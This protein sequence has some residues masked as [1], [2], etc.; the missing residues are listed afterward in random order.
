MKEIMKPHVWVITC[1]VSVSRLMV[2]LGSGMSLKD[3]IGYLR[4]QGRKYYAT[5]KD[6]WLRLE[7]LYRKRLWHQL[8]VVLLKFVQSPA[9]SVGDRILKLY[10]CFVSDFEYKINPMFLVEILIMAAPQMRNWQRATRLFERTIEKV[11]HNDEAF[12]LC[13][14]AMAGAR[15]S[16]V[17]LVGAKSILDGAEA[18]LERM[19]AVT[20]VHAR[21]YTTVCNYYQAL[22]QPALYYKY[23]LRFMACVDVEKL[24]ADLRQQWA[25]P[26]VLAAL[27]ADDVY[28]F[29]HLLMNPILKDL[30]NEERQ[31]L[32]DS[33]T[34]FYHGNIKDY[35]AVRDTSRSEADLTR[36]E[37]KLRKKLQLLCLMEMI[38][39]RLELHESLTFEEI[40]D[41]ANLQLDEVEPLVMKALSYGLVRG[42]IDEVAREIHMTWVR[43]KILDVEQMYDSKDRL[44]SWCTYIRMM[45]SKVEHKAQ[46]LLV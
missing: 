42:T 9:L 35:D 44:D 5:E 40:A 30:Q 7:C 15:M 43:P 25:V 8:T 17:D 27:V 1:K 29:G 12:I 14:T 4:E 33:V 39:I 11:K 28:N 3:V 19:P 34:I 37:K 45:I 2:L 41:D 36:H 23:A 31:W 26:V 13:L 16:A 46:E 18:H 21:F 38:Y 20:P 6:Q 24:S 10:E 32:V 22:G